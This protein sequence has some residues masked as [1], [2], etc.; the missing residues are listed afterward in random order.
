MT[1]VAP[2][3]PKSIMNTEFEITR[4]VRTSFTKYRVCLF[5][6]E[7]LCMYFV[8]CFGSENKYK[9]METSVYSGKVNNMFPF[10]NKIIINKIIYLFILT[11]TID[12][13]H[14]SQ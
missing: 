11:K 12:L 14:Y 1:E 4:V 7:Y 10:L 5:R 3:L 8:I 2:A 6:R 13:L 9:F